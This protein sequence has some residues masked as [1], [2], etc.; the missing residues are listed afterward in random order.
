MISLAAN[1]SHATLPLAGLVIV[2]LAGY[3]G[4]YEDVKELLNTMNVYTRVAVLVVAVLGVTALAVWEGLRL[5]KK[6]K[7]K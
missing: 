2:L 6:K 1:L 7:G 3:D 4:A 5:K